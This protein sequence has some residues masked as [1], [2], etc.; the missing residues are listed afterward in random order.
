MEITLIVFGLIVLLSILMEAIDSSIGMMYGTV[1]SPLLIGLDFAPVDVVPALVLSQAL[2]GVVASLRHHQFK[3]ASFT[4][5]SKDMKVAG[6]IFSLGIVAVIVGACVGVNVNK[7]I[8]SMYIA[9]LMTVMG[10]IVFAGFRLQFRWR[11]ILFIGLI[12]SFNKA[13]SGGGFGPIVT[14]GQ[15]ISGRNGRRSVGATTM[16]EVEICLASYVVWILVSNRVPS[17]LLT[18]AL[19]M[20]AVVGGFIGPAVLK[21]IGNN[22][23]LLTKIV[24]AMAIASGVFAIIKLI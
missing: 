20:G 24:G 2:G 17:L 12:S 19:C 15:L 6:M 18:L 16:S 14:S 7:H 4:W 9:I 8:L 22:N 13:L 21:K 3:N 11:N 1:L 10:V 5:Q 23:V